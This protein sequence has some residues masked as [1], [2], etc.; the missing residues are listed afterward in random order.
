MPLTAFIRSMATGASRYAARCR[1]GNHLYCAQRHLS[2]AHG[3][4]A[5]HGADE[6][7]QAI[8]DARQRIVRALLD[9]QRDVA[10]YQQK[11]SPR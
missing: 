11:C 4:L 2:V 6:Q 5:K 10:A 3:D 9:L 8:E 1:A 7:L